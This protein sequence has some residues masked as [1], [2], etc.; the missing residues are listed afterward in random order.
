MLPPT[1]LS[2][3]IPNVRWSFPAPSLAVFVAL[4]LLDILTTLIGLRLGAQEASVFVGRLI[5]ASPMAGLLIAKLFAALLVAAAIKFQRP[6]VVVFLNYWFTA[7]VTW[8]L[9]M[10]L[11]A[12]AM[13]TR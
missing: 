12:A 5:Q 11:K 3:M 7:V 9:L 2:R 4:Q 13:V 8:N 6:R 10:I 1:P